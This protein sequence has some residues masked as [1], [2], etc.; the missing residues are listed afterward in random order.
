MSV[1]TCIKR[2]VEGSVSFPEQDA[3]TTKFQVGYSSFHFSVRII[4]CSSPYPPEHEHPPKTSGPPPNP[5]PD[6]PADKYVSLT[7]RESV[8][9]FREAVDTARD[10]AKRKLSN[11]GAGVEVKPTFTVDLRNRHLSQLPKEVI[12]FIQYDVE[13]YSSLGLYMC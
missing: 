6:R 1:S 12:A 11:D 10:D 3:R 13:R 4:K 5:I 7:T 2:I 9:L 8:D